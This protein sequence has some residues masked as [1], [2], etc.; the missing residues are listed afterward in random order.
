MSQVVF[1]AMVA[2]ICVL[3]IVV[4]AS[5][6]SRLC[7]TPAEEHAVCFAGGGVPAADIG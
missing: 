2:S 5:P 7:A 1:A 4:I 6:V 3:A